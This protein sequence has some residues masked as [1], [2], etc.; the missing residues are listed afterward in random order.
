MSEA[1]SDI[2]SG[3]GAGPN[4]DA[5]VDQTFQPQTVAFENQNDSYYTAR[6]QS[7]QQIVETIQDVASM[8]SRLTDMIHKQEET[9]VRIDT[10][11]E[12]VAMYVDGANEHIMDLY[13]FSSNNQWLLIKIFAI[14]IVFAIFFVTVIS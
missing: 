14:L 12:E 3:S 9:V 8:H 7:M 1:E 2:E 6:Q 4:F 13:E 5:L 11:I 10:N